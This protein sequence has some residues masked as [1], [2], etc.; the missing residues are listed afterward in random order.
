MLMT[1]DDIESV[2]HVGDSGRH[3]TRSRDE[4]VRATMCQRFLTQ[5]HHVDSEAVCGLQCLTRTSRDDIAAGDVDLVIEG[6][7][8]GLAGLRT[9]QIGDVAFSVQVI[10]HDAVDD[11]R[12]TRVGDDDGVALRDATRNDSSGV[13]TEVILCA[14]DELNR[15]AEGL[16]ALADDRLPHLQCTEQRRPGVPG[17]PVG[18]G[19]DVVADEGA[20]RDGLHVGHIE[21]GRGNTHLADDLLEGRMVV[22]DQIHLVHR[23][24]HGLH[25][26]ERADGEVTMGLR[27]NAASGIDHQHGDVAVRCSDRHV[28]G[29]L[30][31]PRGVCDEDAAAVGEVHVPVGD[32]DRDALLALGLQAVGQQGVVDLAHRDCRTATTRAP[33]VLEGVERHGVG[34]GEEAADER[35]LPVVDRATR[36]QVDDGGQAAGH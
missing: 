11:G 5:P 30:L 17:H 28:A 34:L 4:Q 35:R 31:M 10:G 14:H 9:L 20:D 13:A 26:H 18:G 27:T 19:G 22:A 1:G 24:E 32:V 16:L 7:G 36:H 3:G 33:G 29:V 12:A 23:D 21:A 25:T 15:Q 8:D 2:A 6:E